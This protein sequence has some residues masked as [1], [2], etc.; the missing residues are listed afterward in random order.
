[1]RDERRKPRRRTIAVANPIEAAFHRYYALMGMQ[2]GALPPIS[3]R[4]TAAP[5]RQ[6]NTISLSRRPK[7][8][9][10]VRIERLLKKLSKLSRYND[11]LLQ[12]GPPVSAA[13][14]PIVPAHNSSPN[15]SPN[16]RLVRTSSFLAMG[17]PTARSRASSLN[18]GPKEVVKKGAHDEKQ[19]NRMSPNRVSP[20]MRQV[21]RV[22]QED[23][24]IVKKKQVPP[25]VRNFRV[26]DRPDNMQILK[27]AMRIIQ[28]VNCRLGVNKENEFE[29]NRPKDF[30]LSLSCL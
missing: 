18:R 5:I 13:L 15:I 2:N 4:Q 8:A 23:K 28:D 1:M 24:P 29:Q 9:L 16:M 25:T 21:K 20:E 11:L 19:R 14:P 10:P 7:T 27:T 3:E 17:T 6:R 30:S 26:R 12:S 22:Q